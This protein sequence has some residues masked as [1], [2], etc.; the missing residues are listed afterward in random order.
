MTR[1]HCRLA[2]KLLEISLTIFNYAFIIAPLVSSQSLLALL[3]AIFSATTDKCLRI[4]CEGLL[5]TGLR[6]LDEVKI[7][8]EVLALIDS[9][10][11]HPIE[12][13][14]ASLEGRPSIDTFPVLDKPFCPLLELRMKAL[15]PDS[16]YP[17]Q[18]DLPINPLPPEMEEPGLNAHPAPKLQTSVE[19]QG[20]IPLD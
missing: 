4:L 10:R 20:P 15:G 14:V 13:L 11:V 3:H 5:K 17:K 7:K 16:P 19:G 6:N 12:E 18:F 9:I 1:R 2:F 8:Q